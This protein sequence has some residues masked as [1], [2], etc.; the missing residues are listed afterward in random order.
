LLLKIRGKDKGT[1]IDIHCGNETVG[2][3]NKLKFLDMRIDNQLHFSENISQLS[4][5][6]S[7]QVG[8]LT[9]MK[10]LVP[11]RAKLVI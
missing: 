5:K 1:A 6:E 7:Q 2:Q 10:N 8:A 11:E 9:R 3:S 4:K